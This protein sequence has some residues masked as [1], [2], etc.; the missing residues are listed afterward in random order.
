MATAGRPPKPVEV[1]RRTGNPGKRP[2][3]DQATVTILPGAA[4][5]P[6]P[7]RPLGPSGHDLW[8]RIW[9]SGA[10]W[11]AA[12][13][14]AEAVLLVCE[15]MDERAALRF[16][17]LKDGDWRERAG[18]RA[19]EA[20]I[21]GS[22]SSLGFTPVDRSRLGVA[23]VKPASRIESLLARRNGTAE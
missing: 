23:E 4:A 3:P 15:R 5:P 1:K 16:R 11:L 14:D 13:V 17:V 2:L 20:Q 9:K 21:D 7:Q 6:E 10:T 19:L 22:L 8:D 12:R 18:L